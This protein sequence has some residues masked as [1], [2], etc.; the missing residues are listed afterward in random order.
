[1]NRQLFLKA[2]L[3]ICLTCLVCTGP[4]SASEL[5]PV[6]SGGDPPAAPPNSSDADARRAAQIVVNGKTLTGP[7][8]SAQQIG[9]RIVIPI[10]S[11]A[12]ALG[13][14]VNTVPTVPGART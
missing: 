2:V 12:R 3:V 13:D 11:V 10:A 9:G 7:N 4:V 8:S 14:V 1:M 5:T 6:R